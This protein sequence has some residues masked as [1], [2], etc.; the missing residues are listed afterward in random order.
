MSEGRECSKCGGQM[1]EADRLVA[2]T[3]VPTSISLAK[4]G[5]IIGDR[6]IPFYCGNCGY[7]EFYKEM[8]IGEH[9]QEQ[10]FLMKCVQCGKQ[11]P[12]ASEECQFCRA[13]QNEADE[14]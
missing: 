11:I 3:S 1:F 2:Q 7:I 8:K 5:D 10:G 13:K 4:K 14:R 12:I 9:P 6:I